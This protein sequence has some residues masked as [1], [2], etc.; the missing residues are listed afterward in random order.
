MRLP[1]D[2]DDDKDDEPDRAPA[3]APG[4]MTAHERLIRFRNKFLGIEVAPNVQAFSLVNY[5]DLRFYPVAT[6][7]NDDMPALIDDEDDD[8]MP[9]LVYHPAQANL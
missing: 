9:E 6:G 2:D 7:N 5:P 3:P 4:T 1:E 8:D